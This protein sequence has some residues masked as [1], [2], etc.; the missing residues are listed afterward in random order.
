MI[1]GQIRGS[2]ARTA[3]ARTPAAVLT[4]PG[5]K[6]AGAEPLPG[7]RGVQGVVAAAVRLPRMIS[8]AA[9]RAAGDHTTDRAQL[10]RGFRPRAVPL[11]TLVTLECAPVDITMSVN[12]R[13]AWVYS[14][15]V[16]HPEGHAE[17][18]RASVPG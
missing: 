15:P 7:S 10:H 18:A 4:A 9:T 1:D 3:I 16:L 6:D 11:V 8:A 2:V 14:P 17:V 5:T 12:R 13:G